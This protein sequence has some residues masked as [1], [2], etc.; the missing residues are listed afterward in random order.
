VKKITLILAVILGLGIAGATSGSAAVYVFNPNPVNVYNLDHARY[1]TW[2]ID[3]APRGEQISEVILTFNNIRN[4]RVEEDNLFIHLLDNAPSNLTAGIDG[5]LAIS[6]YFAGQGDLIDA[7]TDPN[8]GL[9]GVNLSYSFR[10]LGL[11]DNFVGYV[12]DGNV[13]IAFDPDCHYYND[14]VSLT[15][16][17]DAPEPTTLAL[18][19]LGLVGGAAARRKVKK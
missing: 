13:G 17:T 5:N 7:W 19:A 11:V 9:P 4:W 6:D 3:F 8:G 14:G 18:F 10:E 15:I 16:I 12:A 1:Y 2:G